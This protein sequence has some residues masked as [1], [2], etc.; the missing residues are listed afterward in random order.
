MNVKVGDGCIL[1]HTVLIHVHTEI[2]DEIKIGD[3]TVI[4]RLPMRA[5]IKDEE[6]SRTV[7][8]DCVIVGS[9]VVIYR[10]RKIGNFVLVADD[11][12]S[13]RENDEL[14]DYTIFGRCS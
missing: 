3:N 11:F 7:I 8:G 14:G 5:V 9:Y 1:G 10:G 13:V 6:L 12:T 2:G 4:G